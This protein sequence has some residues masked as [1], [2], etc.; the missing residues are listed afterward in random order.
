MMKKVSALVVMTLL[1]VLSV[2]QADVRDRLYDFTDAYYLENGIDPAAISGRRQPGPNAVIDT[3][4][5]SFQRN[6]RM[7]ATSPSYDHSGH[8]WYFAILGGFDVNAFTPDAAG[9]RAREI[10]DRYIEYV[11]P[12]RGTNPVGLG[13]AR[14]AVVLDMRNGYFSNNPLG[15]WLHVWV[16]YTDAAFNT[17]EGRRILREMAGRNGQDLDGSA[18][19]ATTSEIDNLFARGLITKLERPLTDPARYSICPVIK[20]PRD[21]GI[22]RDQFLNYV[23]LPDG[24]PL[25]REFIENFKTLQATG[26]PAH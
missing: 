12:R 15:L 19:I 3:P 20:D 7:L 2:T 4:N 24:A 13:A 9:V 10:A 18:I 6:L 17:L 8:A 1:A 14:Q 25:E 5:F 21:G 26:R 22:A 23:R 11:F 16:S